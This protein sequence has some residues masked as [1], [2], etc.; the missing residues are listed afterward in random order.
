MLSWLTLSKTNAAT[1]QELASSQQCLPVSRKHLPVYLPVVC[2]LHQDL[3]CL[4]SLGH[5]WKHCIVLL[6]QISRVPQLDVLV[7]QQQM[8]LQYILRIP[9]KASCY[10]SRVFVV[11]C[12]GLW[13]HHKKATPHTN[14]GRWALNVN[15]CPGGM[16]FVLYCRGLEMSGVN[17]G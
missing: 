10:R 9:G 8:L 5:I 11:V 7:F 4:Q 12:H 15:L 17:Y 2:Y 3:S 14:V 1:L 16:A 6:V 13:K